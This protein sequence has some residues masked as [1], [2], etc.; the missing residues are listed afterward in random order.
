MKNAVIYSAV[1]LSVFYLICGNAEAGGHRRMHH[2][3]PALGLGFLNL[4]G[5]GL[6]QQNDSILNDVLRQLLGKLKD[7]ADNG[8]DGSV[9]VA[10]RDVVPNPDLVAANSRMD[11]VLSK[12]GIEAPHFDEEQHQNQTNSTDEAFDDPVVIPDGFTFPK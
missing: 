5:T 3:A 4:I 6:L 8:D 2:G 9:M 10:K 12:L 7:D 1:L 11:R